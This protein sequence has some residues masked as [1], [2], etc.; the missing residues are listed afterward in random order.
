MPFTIASK[1]WKC[2]A[3]GLSV[4]VGNGAKQFGNAFRDR[5]RGEKEANLEQAIA[6]YQQA[7]DVFIATHIQLTGHGLTAT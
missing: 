7:V 4:P 1:R 5:I 6:W 3:H 2:L